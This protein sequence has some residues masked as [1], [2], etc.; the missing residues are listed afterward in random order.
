MLSRSVQ[1]NYL[2]RKFYFT[3]LC[4]GEGSSAL[5]RSLSTPTSN[6]ETIQSPHGATSRCSFFESPRELRDRIYEFA[7]GCYSEPQKHRATAQQLQE[8]I[9]NL[10][11]AE[12]NASAL[13]AFDPAF[14]AA[15]VSSRRRRAENQS[16]VPDCSSNLSNA[17]GLRCFKSERV[18][19]SNT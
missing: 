3:C 2:F 18:Q 15:W 9:I 8:G 19:A 16:P 6:T 7:F 13:I 14:V 17:R 1:S 10:R 12:A 11:D 4:G 5:Q